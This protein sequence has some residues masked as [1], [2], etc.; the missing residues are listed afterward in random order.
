MSTMPSLLRSPAVRATI[1]GVLLGAWSSAGAGIPI[2]NVPLFIGNDV[3]ANIFLMLDDSGSMDWEVLGRRPNAQGSGWLDFSPHS[4]SAS[5]SIT[6]DLLLC[7]GYNTM[8]YN[9]NVTYTPWVGVDEDGV[10]YAN[11]SISAARNDPYDPDA[12]VTNLLSVDGSGKPTL[13]GQWTDTNGDNLYQS[14]ECPIGTTGFFSYAARVNGGAFSNPRFV[15]VNTLTATQQTNFANWYT[16][17]RKRIYVLKRAISELVSTSQQRM[18][19]ATL[20][21]N[22]NVATPI[23]F[24]TDPSAKSTLMSN[25][26][27]VYPNGATP[28]QR[29]L[30]LVGHY[31][32]QTDS[33]SAD[34][35]AIGFSDPSPI[36]ASG[37][38]GE[39]QQNFAILLSDG[40][41]NAA[42][43]IP[44]I[45][46]ADG[47]DDT[48]FDGGPTADAVENTL[49]DVAMHYYE[50]DLAPTLANTVPTIS[51]VDENSAQHLV[52]YTV[53]FG[54]EGTLS[55]VPSDYDAATP[56]PPWPTPSSDAVTTADD[57]RHAAYNARGKYLPGQDP[58]ELIRTLNDAFADISA[59][60][61][62]AAA[63][64]ATSTSLRIGTLIFSP[65][66]ETATWS[67]KLYAQRFLSG[68]VVGETLWEASELIPDSAE[69][70][71][72]TWDDEL[73][74]GTAFLWANLTT[75]QQAAI[76]SEDILDYIRGDRTLELSSGG[77]FRS[78]ASLLGDIS[79]SSPAA[80]TKDQSP[81][82]YDRLP[83]S[84]GSTYLAFQ[85]SK[86]A[87][88]DMVYVGANDGMLHGFRTDSGEEVLAYVPRSVFSTLGLLTAPNYE[89]RYYVDGEVNAGDAYLGG[90]W[91]SVL[92]GS[93]G[94]GASAVFALDVSVPTAFDEGSVLWEFSAA[95]LGNITHRPLIM[96]ANNGKWVA[97][98][99]NGYNSASNRA[100]LFIVDLATGTV[101]KQIDTGA[102]DADHPNGLAGP[103]LLDPNLDINVDTVYAGDLLGNLWKFDLSSNDPSDWGIAEF[104]NDGGTPRPLYRAVGPDG[105]PQ[106]IT[107]TPT[108]AV[109]SA[110]GYQILFGTGRYLATGDDILGDPPTVDSFY[111]IRDQGAAILDSVGARPTPGEGT[112]P[113]D[114][115]QPQ[116]MLIEDVQD[117]DGF[118]QPVGVISGN[119][120]NYSPGPGQQFGWYLDI[121]SPATGPV[122]ERV[123]QSP[124]VL[125]SA[126]VFTTYAPKSDCAA[127]GFTSAL[128][129]V[130]ATTG[131]RTTFSIFDINRDD[132][133]DE[134]DRA[135]LGDGTTEVVSMIRIGTTVAPV[136]LVASE[137]GNVMFGLT[138]ELDSGGG[139][140]NDEEG[141]EID[142]D[143][144]GVYR[145]RPPQDSIGRQSW[146]QVR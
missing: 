128:V 123:I 96:R 5:A 129:A 38:V 112:Q 69:R 82:P 71:I 26:F 4:F 47:D 104:S 53:S 102:G 30:D 34:H 117:F 19:L 119:A 42:E 63:V 145:L 31:F 14:G 36:L 74:S 60:L 93:T 35:S 126:V 108:V 55:A 98:F 85:R 88:L 7:V 125:G 106:A 11:Q 86:L 21:N 39:C 48:D 139:T 75:T 101:L 67:G 52:T 137:D 16:Y 114:L 116:Q 78:R 132:A 77:P 121:V 120:V 94:R 68:G 131:G 138:T 59:R 105:E 6:R 140:T 90:A 124:I 1:T 100:Q 37:D 29:A 111:G 22:N 61:G 51:G 136:T 25:M 15:F 73:G 79:A 95:E 65:V 54:L 58:E 76:G 23:A 141:G 46:N 27:R 18:G 43:T 135:D 9:P 143:D 99:G 57:M 110:G 84:E 12:G 50:R 32:D 92:V 89:H 44:D 97:I 127:G 80:V 8:A 56:S 66:F 130:D 83:G 107:T 40:Y 28:L 10:P 13:F 91:K 133:F 62:T 142:A 3:P 20:W 87:R 17:Y 24:M 45:G 113:S 134:Q 70:N 33:G 72:L 81:R 41:W 118:D 144:P 115:L 146:R 103:L 49:A 64:S 122:G 2:P 109:N